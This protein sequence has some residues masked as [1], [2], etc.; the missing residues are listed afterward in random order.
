MSAY[1][2]SWPCP[3]IRCASPSPSW[4]TSSRSAPTC[5]RRRKTRRKSRRSVRSVQLPPGVLC[6]QQVRSRFL[7]HDLSRLHDIGPVGDA[8]GG[9]DVLLDQDDGGAETLVDLARG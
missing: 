1:R 3:P 9:L 6:R 2:V 5:W 7:Q 4:T 8:E